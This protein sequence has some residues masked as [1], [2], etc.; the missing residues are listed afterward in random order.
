MAKVRQDPNCP[1]RKCRY[2]NVGVEFAP[3]VLDNLREISEQ[4]HV[5][6]F[7]V[8]RRAVYEFCDR[9]K[10]EQSRGMAE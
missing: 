8:I 2:I 9:F 1:E 3:M 7:G 5:S 6:V 10:R 4:M